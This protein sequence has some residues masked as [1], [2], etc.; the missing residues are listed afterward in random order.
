MRTFLLTFNPQRWHLPEDE[1]LDDMEVIAAGGL[2]PGRWSTGRRDMNIGDRVYLLRQGP[3]PR[4]IIASGW[5]ATEP[6]EDTHWDEDQPG[7]ADYVDVHWDAMAP[8]D[9]PLVTTDLLTVVNEVPWNNLYRGGVQVDEPAAARL[10]ALW[11]AHLTTPNRNAPRHTGQGHL[12]GAVARKAIE[13][14]AQAVLTIHYESQGWTVED[15]RI[16]NP[17]DAIATKEDQVHYL[18]AKGTQGS[19]AAVL[20]TA[21][22]VAFAQAHPGRCVMGI[23]SGILLD[24]NGAIIQGSGSLRIVPWNPDDDDLQDVTLRWHVPETA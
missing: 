11:R 13:D 7:L 20:V 14:H 23:V 12:P 3:E 17:Y 2:A 9:D 21:G 6:Y 18:E 10:N 24:K 4:G 5:T 8:L 1:W 15:T 19:G 16:G 22:E